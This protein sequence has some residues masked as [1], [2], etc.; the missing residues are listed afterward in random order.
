MKNLGRSEV[1]KRKTAEEWSLAKKWNPFNSFKL[2]AHVYRWE[3]I[4][5]GNPIPQPVLVTVDPVN[6]CDLNCIWCNSAYVLGARTGIMS[7]KLLLDVARFLSEW[8][9]A[10]DWHGGV[11]A[12]CIAGGGE[13]LLN[14][15]IGDFINSLVKHGIGVGIVTNGTSIDKFIEPLSK[16]TWVG[17]SV[18]AG[19]GETFKKLK[20][21]DKFQKFIC[22]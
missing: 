4:V 20:G 15:S 17:V 1:N 22:L 11:E 10:P 5:R 21:K 18:D 7:K 19:S 14:P 2:M 16:C 9:S 12:V 3:K 8:K 13:P 6:A